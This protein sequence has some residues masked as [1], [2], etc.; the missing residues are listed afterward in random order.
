MREEDLRQL[1][2]RMIYYL[3]NMFSTHSIQTFKQRA[4]LF[5][6]FLFQVNTNKPLEERRAT[7]APKMNNRRVSMDLIRPAAPPFGSRP[8]IIRFSPGL[9]GFKVDPPV[10]IPSPTRK[11]KEW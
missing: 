3:R 10:L 4:Y 1:T 6:L 5:P 2:I 11:A 7:R 9:S 8:S